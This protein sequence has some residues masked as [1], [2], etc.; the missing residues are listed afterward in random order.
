[1]CAKAKGKGKMIDVESVVP[2]PGS[3]IKRH[4]LRLN[5]EETYQNTLL[6]PPIQVYSA[7]PP[8]KKKSIKL[9]P[10]P[11]PKVQLSDKKS[12][13]SKKKRDGTPSETESLEPPSNKLRRS[14]RKTT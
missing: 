2:E 8:S 11:K 13:T 9:T 14:L 5:D 10:P 7:S 6:E 1:M 12:N 4:Q 3:K